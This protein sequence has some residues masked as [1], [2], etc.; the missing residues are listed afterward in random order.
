MGTITITNPADGE[1]IDAADV[2][3]PFNTIK[4]CI[5]G[6]IDADNLSSTIYVDWADWVPVFTNL[7]GGTLNYAK[8]HRVGNSVHFILK[9]TLT[10]ANISGSV[11]CNLPVNT[12]TDLSPQIIG[13]GELLD[14][15]TNG[16]YSILSLASTS[17]FSI[18]CLN[19]A[20]TYAIV[21]NIN[22][23][24]PFTWA[25]TDVIYIRGH[26]PIV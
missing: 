10:G 16:F 13:Q 6:N 24:V 17:T 26:Y 15:G 4:A 21:S 12:T 2:A 19:T 11:T 22:A 23:T 20:S 14:T 8:Y 18:W 3:T 1:T 9:Y 7:A 25:N 5:N